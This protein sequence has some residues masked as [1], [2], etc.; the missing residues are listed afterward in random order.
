MGA[1]LSQVIS[2]SRVPRI[3]IAENNGSTAAS[4]VQSISA[5]RLDLDYEVC[6]SHDHAVM[7]LF[8]SPP[9]YTLVISSVRLAEKDNYLLL[10]HN[11]FRQ[12]DVPFVITTGVAEVESARQAMEAG[13][14]DLISTPLEPQQT[15]E[16]IRLALW[17]NTLRAFIASRDQVIEKFR[18]HIAN[19][20][21]DLREGELFQRALALLQETAAYTGESLQRIEESIVRLSDFA[22]KVADDVRQRAEARLKTMTK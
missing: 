19:C 15:V 14:F 6:R 21:S 5:S 9:P 16:T 8:R 3:L 1:D 12:P 10:K 22:T 17:H 18:Q 7:H 4:L 11:R 13:A 2:T 20:P